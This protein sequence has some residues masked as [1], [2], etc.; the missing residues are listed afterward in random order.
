[1]KVVGGL[2][3]RGP[4]HHTA[5]LQLARVRHA[6]A[7]KVRADLHSSVHDSQVLLITGTEMAAG[8]A[9]RDLAT[10]GIATTEGPKV[11]QTLGHRPGQEGRKPVGSNHRK[12]AMAVQGLG[13]G[14]QRQHILPAFVRQTTTSTCRQ[15]HNSHRLRHPFPQFHLRWALATIPF[16]H[17]HR[18]QTTMASGQLIRTLPHLHLR[19]VSSLSEVGLLLRQL[20]PCR[21]PRHPLNRRCINPIS[22]VE[23]GMETIVEEGA[24]MAAGVVEGGDVIDG[25]EHCKLVLRFAYRGT[26]SRLAVLKNKKT[27][28]E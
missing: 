28:N 22:M 27:T 20:Q 8:A 18:H 7:A 16:P 14:H 3:R 24:D 23:M 21:F 5:A 26:T 11:T 12:P 19:K 6:G 13:A 10:V 25:W 1:M 9:V 4:Q 2:G 15:P 17:H